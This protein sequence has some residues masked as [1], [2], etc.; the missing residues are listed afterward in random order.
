MP[1]KRIHLVRHGEVYNPGGVLYG[2]LPNFHLSDTG[3]AMAKES[4]EQLKLIAP[5][6]TAIYCSPLV[7]AQES[8]KPIEA[9]FGIDAKIEEKLIE[10]HNVFEGQKQPPIGKQNRT[11]PQC[12]TGPD[13]PYVPIVG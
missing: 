11:G 4:A 3:H 9:I 5:D 1:A 2:R 13:K 8:A 6:V 10:P 12:V 7:R